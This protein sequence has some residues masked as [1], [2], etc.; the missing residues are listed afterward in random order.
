M[1][2]TAEPTRWLGSPAHDQEEPVGRTTESF[3]TPERTLEQRMDALELANH[4][5][6]RRAAFKRDLK[7][8]RES[9]S[10]LL[11]DPPDYMLTARVFD[12]LL[13]VPR[14]GRVKVNRV[15]QVLRI[16]PNKTIGGLSQRQRAELVSWLGPASPLGLS[17]FELRVLRAAYLLGSLQGRHLDEAVEMLNTQY[18]HVARARRE[19]TERGLVDAHGHV[20]PTGRAFVPAN[21]RAGE[22]CNGDAG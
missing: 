19:L 22:L 12:V 7:A 5:R 16:S 3:E 4:I 9:V 17:G 1:T 15:L 10:S 21:D 20:T 18:S 13:A 2:V 8:G 6:I 11:V 14:Y